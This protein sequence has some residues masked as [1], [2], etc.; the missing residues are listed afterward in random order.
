MRAVERVLG[1]HTAPGMTIG[2]GEDEWE[3]TRG[4]GLNAGCSVFLLVAH[5]GPYLLSTS[6]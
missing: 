6:S 5:T 2:R 3:T 4:V 1:A